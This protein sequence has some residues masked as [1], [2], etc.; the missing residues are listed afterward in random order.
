MIHFQKKTHSALVLT[1]LIAAPCSMARIAKECPPN[2]EYPLV[3]GSCTIFT[4]SHGNKVLFGNNE[5]W[6]LPTTF[7]WVKLPNDG[8]Y[9]GVYLGHRSE[10]EIRSRGLAGISAQGGVNEKGLA[11]DYAALPESQVTSHPEFPAK[12]AIMMKIQE[13]CA[14]VKEAIAMAKTH[15]WG[16]TLR[17]QVLLA[18]ATG[19]AVVISAGEDGELAF[20]RK[21]AGDGYLLTTNFNRADPKNTFEGSYPCWRYNKAV[22]MLEKIE[23][24]R[25]LTADY[26]RSILKAVQIEDAVGNTEYS[27]VFDLRSGVIYLNHWHQYDETAAIDVA[28]EIAK[29]A[30]GRRSIDGIAEEPSPVRIKDLF[31]PE[32][33]QRAE[34]EH[35]EYKKK[36]SKER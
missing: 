14:T 22:D 23:S 11:F 9:G 24:K 15:D 7:Y 26:F 32:T 29:H 28:K 16:T 8:S 21:P 25:D 33:V 36:K 19:D 6:M 10:E 2:E 27:N 34:R 13:R 4:A 35:R 31:S 3:L 17:W 30:V 18:D 20:T 1:L 12:G 5:D